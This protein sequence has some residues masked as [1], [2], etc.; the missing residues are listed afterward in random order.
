MKTNRERKSIK[1]KWRIDRVNRVQ[2][3]A[4]PNPAS[5]TRTRKKVQGLFAI[6]VIVEKRGKEAKRINSK[7]QIR[8]LWW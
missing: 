5:G 1:S 6:L 3:Q 8:L 4:L 7:Q 2:S